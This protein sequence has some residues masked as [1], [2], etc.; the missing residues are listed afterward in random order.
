MRRLASPAVVLVTL[1]WALQV[2]A[3]AET[4]EPT[5]RLGKYVKGTAPEIRQMLQGP[6]DEFT[7][8]TKDAKKRLAEC[9]AAIAAARE[10]AKPR[11][12][13]TKRYRDL[14]ASA[15]AAQ[16]EL[17]R[18][19]QSGT[20]RQKLDASTRLN[21]LRTTLAKMEADAVANDPHIARLKARLAEEK[22]SVERCQLS[23]E[24]ATTWRDQWVY[25]IECTFRIAAPVQVG[26]QGVL[27][28]VRVL[29]PNS[30][31]HEGVLVLY[32]A[33]EQTGLG[34][35]V[36]GIQMVNVVM[37][38]ER[39]LLGPDTPGAAGAKKGDVLELF[40]TYRV[41]SMTTD[42]DGPVYVTARRPHEND[43]LMAEMM[44]LRAK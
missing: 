44:A 1:S 37:K 6:V 38:K 25:A 32:E 17:D 40:R 42:A 41:E 8:K 5:F 23:L 39:L 30:P 15:E 4:A 12:R 36:E 28:T 3:A 27:T 29:K 33:A 7:T 31:T 2:P 11:L 20:A 34:G 19:R 18:V 35:Q 21:R 16:R 26:S 24:K 43:A 13:E 14:E 10:G 22:E 9:E